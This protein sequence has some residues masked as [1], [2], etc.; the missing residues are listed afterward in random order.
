MPDPRAGKNIVTKA[1]IVS[2]GDCGDVVDAET[3]SKA[4]AFAI[5]EWG[6]QWHNPWITTTVRRRKQW[7]GMTYDAIH[8]NF[9]NYGRERSA[10]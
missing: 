2:Q 5:R 7:D 1:W 10:A 4:K 8:K 6:D 3:G 9:D